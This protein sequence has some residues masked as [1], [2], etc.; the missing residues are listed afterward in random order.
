MLILFSRR[1]EKRRWGDSVA[2]KIALTVLWQ[3]QGRLIIISRD[4]LSTTSDERRPL[5]WRGSESNLPV[6]EKILN[7]TSGSFAGIVGVYQRHSFSE[8]K[9]SALELWDRFVAQLVTESLGG[10]SFTRRPHD[11]THAA[12]RLAKAIERTRSQ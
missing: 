10:A 1:R 7:H 3:G 5:G 9:R 2:Q 12:P 4:G 8:E 11:N 6:I